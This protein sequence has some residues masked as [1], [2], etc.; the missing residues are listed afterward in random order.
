[1]KR[2]AKVLAVLLSTVMAVTAIPV[3]NV[4][5][6]V[7]SEVKTGY[8]A[9]AECVFAIDNKNISELTKDD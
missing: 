8:V 6:A 4:S 9:Q 3:K 2:A 7:I 1:M 5:A